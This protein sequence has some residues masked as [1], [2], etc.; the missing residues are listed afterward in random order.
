VGAVG[1][2]IHR[3]TPASQSSQRLVH[4]DARDPCAE[5]RI[6]TEHVEAREGAD[7]S[8]LHHVLGF[9]VV[10]EDASCNAEQAAIVSLGKSANRGFV[11]PS[12][13]TDQTLIAER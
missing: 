10:A 7:I 3:R 1:F 11:A 5:G 13:Q 9:R 4:G 8:L 2:P 12:C 6:A